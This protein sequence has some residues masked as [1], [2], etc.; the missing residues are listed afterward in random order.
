MCATAD[1]CAP[2]AP[3][4]PDPGARTRTWELYVLRRADGAL[5]TGIST[6]VERRLREHSGAG[7]RGA[8]SLRARGPLVLAYRV[9]VG[10]RALALRAESRV[11]ALPK[12][13]KEA[14]VAEQPD[15]ASLLA[16]LGLEHAP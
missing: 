13:R 1:A 3:T 11:K 9:V 7:M 14:L 12:S 4:A 8:R 5:Y 15:A 2:P 6:D 16:R 10:T